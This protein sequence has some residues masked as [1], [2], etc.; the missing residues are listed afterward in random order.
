MTLSICFASS[1]SVDPDRASKDEPH[2][3]NNLVGGE[4]KSTTVLETIV[5]P[6]NGDSM[7][8]VP[9]TSIEESEEFRS[10]L[11]DCPKSGLHNP[12]RGVDR[13]T[14]YGAI[15]AEAGAE[16]RKPNVEHYFSRCI[17]RVAPKSLAQATAEVVV[18][19][20]FLENFSGDQIRFMARSFSVTGD[21]DGQM[22]TGWRW[23]YGP[24]AIVAPFNFPLEIPVLQF[25]G[26]LFMGNKVLFKNDSKVTVVVEQVLRMLH[27]CGMPKKDLDFFCGSGPTFGA[28]LKNAQPRITQ[29]TGSNA[30]ANKLVDEL[31][32]KVLLED[33]GFDWKILG[34]FSG[35]HKTSLKEQ[36]PY[37][38]FVCDQD[39]YAFSGQKCSAQ[40]MLFVHDDWLKE[41]LL[42][43]LEKLAHRRNLNDLTVGPMLS[44]TTQRAMDHVKE[45]LTIPESK[46]LF[47]GNPLQE[48][49][50]IPEQYGA[51]EPTAV[52]IPLDKLIMPE[53][54]KLCSTEIF[55]PLQLVTGFADKTL[56]DVLTACELMENHLTAAIVSDDPEFQRL[57]LGN[58]VNGTTYKGLRARTTGAPQWHW[59]GPAGDPRGA[60]IGTIEAIRHVWSCHRE[61]VD[62]SGPVLTSKTGWNLPPA[63]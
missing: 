56:N 34:P 11:N 13:Y 22:S 1:F 44:V 24:S 51:F 62:D 10:S 55:G 18:T 49:H 32:G 21:H 41:G 9:D 52:W 46:L 14:M 48:N 7:I 4:W 16:M 37:V 28:L 43:Y 47:G 5:D 39:A 57:I 27:H 6:M 20:K 35:N 54:F 53:Y 40:S 8:Y 19:R 42:P 17:Q 3:V 31:K 30:I 2:C 45:L 23:P 60:G 12:F 26:A 61:I 25:M 33:A 36:L 63:T 29:F 50:S 58:T 59:F 38:S 15:C